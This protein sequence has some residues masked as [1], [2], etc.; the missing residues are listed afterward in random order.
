MK[1]R[2]IADELNDAGLCFTDDELVM[3]LLGGLV[4]EFDAIVVNLTIRGDLL[5]LSEVQSVLHTHEKRF[6]QHS[7]SEVTFSTF[8][9][10]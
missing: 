8:V 3:Y 10:K 7:S 5:T 2:S 1:M 9:S 6:L 4:P